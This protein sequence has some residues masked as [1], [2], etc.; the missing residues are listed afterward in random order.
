M[1]SYARGPQMEL[2]E[3]THQVFEQT[4]TRFPDRDALIVRHQNVL[5]TWRQ[6]ADEVERT[7]RGLIGL[8]LQSGDRVGVWATNCAEWIY[9]QLGCARAG[10]VQVNVNPAYRAHELAYVLKKSG[11]KALVLR[12]RDSRSD[13]REILNDAMRG[14]DLALRHIVSLGENSW[15]R[16]IAGGVDA[17]RGPTDQPIDA[18]KYPVH[19]RHHRISEGRAA[20]AS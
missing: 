11:M 6:L 8:G 20:D 12:S 17:G 16:M 4:L 1:E 9:L 10:L 13:Y 3:T 19:L 7:A 15:E 14:Q 18:R 2:T 5:L